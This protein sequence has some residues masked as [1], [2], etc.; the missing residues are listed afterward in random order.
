MQWKQYIKENQDKMEKDEWR[1]EYAVYKEKNLWAE[2]NKKRI[3]IRR[4]KRRMKRNN[5]NKR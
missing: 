1:K 2:E 4:A 5:N 3:T